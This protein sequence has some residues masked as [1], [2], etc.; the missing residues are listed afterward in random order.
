[1]AIELQPADES[2]PAQTT[3]VG[4]RFDPPDAEGRRSYL[5]WA[6]ILTDP[7][8]AVGRML[9]VRATVTATSGERVSA[10]RIVIP[11]AGDHPPPACIATTP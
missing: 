8:C 7:A 11:S 1:M 4:I 3:S 6:A 9:R 2:E 10:E 5:G